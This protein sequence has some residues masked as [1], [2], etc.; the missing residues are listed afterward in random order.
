MAEH[1]SSP[2]PSI[3]LVVALWEQPNFGGRKRTFIDAPLDSVQP[4]F[5]P[6]LADLSNSNF[7]G[8]TN[9]IGIHPGPNFDSNEMRTVSFFAG[10]NY[11]GDELCLNPGAYANLL[12][13]ANFGGKISS[14]R[15]NAP[16]SRPAGYY[17]PGTNNSIL[18]PGGY[19]P[20][21]SAATISPIPLVVKLFPNKLSTLN[22]LSGYP[23][24]A[25]ADLNYLTLVQ[26]AL[27]I[28]AM[29]GA[30]YDQATKAVVVQKGPN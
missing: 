23:Q 1:A 15:F 20:T 27:N 11:G 14:I 10:A 28:G 12:P 26:D 21:S 18:G 13:L 2:I 6:D 4:S 25:Q 8:V 7:N 30:E 5:F 24:G 9:A 3:P 29:F 19:P 22:P 16:N 17:L